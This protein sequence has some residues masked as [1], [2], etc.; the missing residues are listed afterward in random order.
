MLFAALVRRSHAVVRIYRYRTRG[1]RS[2]IEP[3][4][5][6]ALHCSLRRTRHWNWF[7]ADALG[8]LRGKYFNV[9]QSIRIGEGNIRKCF[10]DQFGVLKQDTFD[11]LGQYPT[12]C[13]SHLLFDPTSIIRFD[14]SA[15]PLSSYATAL[16]SAASPSTWTTKSHTAIRMA[17][18]AAVTTRSTSERSTQ[19]ST[20]R[21][22]PMS[23]TTPSGPTALTSESLDPCAQPKPLS[24]AAVTHAVSLLSP[25]L[26]PVGRQLES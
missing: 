20:P 26:A 3:S 10:Q 14:R 6:I 25:Q 19:R 22:G 23:S 21:T 9:V 7:N 13:G 4:K 2:E 18:R 5:L 24:I 1:P 11:I 17:A 12:L 16:A 15:D 8:M